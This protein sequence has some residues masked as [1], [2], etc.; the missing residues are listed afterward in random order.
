ML[1][2]LPHHSAGSFFEL[3]RK[4]R[5]LFGVAGII[6]GISISL[7]SALA[8][9]EE[10]TSQDAAVP[11]Y[12]QPALPLQTAMIH[13]L[14]NN[15]DALTEENLAEYYAL[16]HNSYFSPDYGQYNA[17]MTTRR[18]DNSGQKKNMDSFGGVFIPETVWTLDV[19][20]GVHLDNIYGEFG[21]VLS[22]RHRNTRLVADSQV[23]DDQ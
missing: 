16:L 6:V 11:D 9:I 12:Y 10:A 23:I 8:E 1:E 4:V 5:T 19:S 2:L 21:S 14:V 13:F 22:G 17:D 7:S 20:T 3:N 15:A 18:D